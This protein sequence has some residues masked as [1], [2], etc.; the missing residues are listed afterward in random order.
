MTHS[1]AALWGLPDP[2][3]HGEFYADTTIKRFFAWIVDTVLV[4]GLCIVILPFTAFV[5]IFFFAALFLGIGLIYRI[6]S[7]ATWS[8]TPGMR[9]MS[10][11]FRN[12]YGE[13]FDTGMAV[14]HTLAYTAMASVFVVQVVSILCMLTTPRGQGLHDMLLGTA[15]INRSRNL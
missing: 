2:D 9:L 13:R 7:I 4:V 12:R 11:E 15:A 6:W 5:G 1:D 10:I 8:A 14:L 3:T